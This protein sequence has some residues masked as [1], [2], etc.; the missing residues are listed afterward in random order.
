MGKG[1]RRPMKGAKEI[2]FQV[3][4]DG[5]SRAA[6][7]G[8]AAE[9]LQ[10]RRTLFLVAI[11]SLSVFREILTWVEHEHE[12]Q[13][14]TIHPLEERQR[15]IYKRNRLLHN[16]APADAACAVLTSCICET[17]SDSILK[18]CSCFCCAC[19]CASR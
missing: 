11:C 6:K 14:S 4:Q 7:R 16:G 8:A 18:L 15:G 12:R 5:R 3:Q 1:Q 19:F 17:S 9:Q 2:P 10:N 13:K